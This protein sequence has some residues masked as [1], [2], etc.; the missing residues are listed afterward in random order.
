M[1][2]CESS[3]TRDDERSGRGERAPRRTLNLTV[4]RMSDHAGNS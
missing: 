1:E 3:L 2:H 4:G